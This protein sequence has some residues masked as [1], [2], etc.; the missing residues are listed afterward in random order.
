MS[1]VVVW[2]RDLITSGEQKAELTQSFSHKY[3]KG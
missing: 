1:G 3:Q 2:A